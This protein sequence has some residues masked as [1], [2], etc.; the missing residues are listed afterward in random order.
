MAV[1]ITVTMTMLLTPAFSPKLFAQTNSSPLVILCYSS[2]L[3]NFSKLT[4]KTDVSSQASEK[5]DWM[6]L[7]VVVRCFGCFVPH[8][9]R[10][11]S[12]KQTDNLSGSSSSAE[13]TRHSP[14]EFS[15]SMRFQIKADSN[16][17][18][19]RKTCLQNIASVSDSCNLAAC[20]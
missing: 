18:I 12:S 5:K 2:H 15:Y 8:P 14:H 9:L 1:T 19:H 3:S 4:R 13:A 7:A 20:S 11:G 6:F 10:D 16:S 17:I